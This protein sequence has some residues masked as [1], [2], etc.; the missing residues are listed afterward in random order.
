M[1]VAI[2]AVA[3][4]PTGSGVNSISWTHTP[5][6]TPSAVGV[7]VGGWLFNS[8]ISGV[9]YG[10]TALTANTRYSIAGATNDANT[11]S[12]GLT[13][14]PTGAQTVVVN[15]TGAYITA[16]SITVTGSNTTTCFSH[17]SG[18][19]DTVTVTS[20]ASVTSAAGE[21]VVDCVSAFSASGVPN[22]TGGSQT[23]QY[24]V[25][26]NGN[27]NFGSSTQPGAA[28]TVTATWNLDIGAT[29]HWAASID[30]FKVAAVAAAAAGSTMPMMGVG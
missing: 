28:G 1:A 30:S 9:T 3:N 7:W 4:G 11:Q 13:S 19:S 25:F 22:V 10:G 18:N 6:G 23:T 2:D 17:S 27:L 15:V 14:P 20:T 29:N 5:S 12:F 24:A 26:W 16:T 21:L 8:T